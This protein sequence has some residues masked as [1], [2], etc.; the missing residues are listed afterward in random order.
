[1]NPV[2]CT[3]FLFSFIIERGRSHCFN[4]INT[5]SKAPESYK[6]F[7]NVTTVIMDF[8]MTLILQEVLVRLAD[9]LVCQQHPL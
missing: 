2:V 4:V 7:F 3:V 9:H 8:K 1:M 5:S 6:Y